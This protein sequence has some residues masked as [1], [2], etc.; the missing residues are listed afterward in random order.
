MRRYVLFLLLFVGSGWLFYTWYNELIII[1]WAHKKTVAVPLAHHRERRKIVLHYHAKNR[2]LKDEQDLIVSDDK[3]FSLTTI[4]TV[5]LHL[6]MQEHI[7]RKPVLLQQVLLDIHEQEA[8]LSFDMSLFD[9]N[10]S[11]YEKMMIVEGL[12]KTIREYYPKLQSVMLL[13]NNQPLKDHHLL[14][15]R[16]WPIMGFTS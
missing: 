7:L 5:W 3:S 13:V 15:S 14:F 16:S 1:S 2:W 12:L 8:Y 11:V 10:Q 9:E 6:L 4:I